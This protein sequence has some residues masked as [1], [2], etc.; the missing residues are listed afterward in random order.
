MTAWREGERRVTCAGAH[1]G[2]ACR[3][4]ISI[5]VLIP[6]AYYASF[7]RYHMPGTTDFNFLPLLVAHDHGRA[8]AF[9]AVVVPMGA[10][11]VGYCRRSDLV[12]GAQI[13]LRGSSAG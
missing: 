9:G 13:L 11:R 12:D 4:P 8:V 1:G 7:L 10:A 6:I 2:W 3:C 5:F